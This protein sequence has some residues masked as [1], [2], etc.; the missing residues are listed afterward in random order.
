MEKQV[1]QDDVIYFIM[2]DRFFGKSKKTVAGSDTSMHGGTLDG[3]LDKIAYLQELGVTAIWVTPAYENI[4]DAGGAAPYHYYWPQKFDRV[5]KRLLDGTHLPTSTGMET[6]GTFVD[7]CEGKGM[8]VILDMVVN[9]AGLRCAG[10][11]RFG[12][13]QR[14]RLGRYQ[15]RVVRASGFQSRQ[16]RSSRLFHPEH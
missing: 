2:T 7:L 1:T 12:M 10:P 4:K 6:F 13:V 8:K 16:S 9:H 5:D 3:I 11:I 15:G 14:R